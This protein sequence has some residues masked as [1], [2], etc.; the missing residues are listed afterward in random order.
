MT[1]AEI[2]TREG[3]RGRSSYEATN[4][5]WR[6]AT[7]KFKGSRELPKAEP[8]PL[9]RDC[10]QLE[11]K[12]HPCSESGAGGLTDEPLRL[13]HSPRPLPASLKAFTLPSS[14]LGHPAGSHSPLPIRRPGWCGSAS[15]L[16]PAGTGDPH[17]SLG[18]SPPQKLSLRH[19]GVQA[20]QLSSAPPRPPTAG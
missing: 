9:P 2:E 4:Y 13:P 7:L 20:G 10:K 18:G 11:R 8:P 3:T 12:P 1:A 14:R 15:F 6:D 5:P 19:H 16:L 17:T